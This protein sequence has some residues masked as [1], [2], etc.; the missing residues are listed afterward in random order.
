MSA[1]PQSPPSAIS[2][3]AAST[4]TSPTLHNFVNNLYTMSGGRTPEEADPEEVGLFLS[5][6][7]HLSFENPNY[8]MM[9]IDP[10]RLDDHLNSN[11]TPAIP[12]SIMEEI[13]NELE[14]R[15][16]PPQETQTDTR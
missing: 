5:E 10:S 3:A 15:S 14:Q 16:I 9:L 8:Q 6:N 12:L 1:D 4:A 13:R 11:V 2:L 7:G